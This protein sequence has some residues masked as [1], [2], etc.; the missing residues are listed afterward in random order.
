MPDMKYGDS[1]QARRFSHV[2]GYVGINRIAVRE[3][4]RQ[5][6]DLRLD[7]RGIATG[8]LLV[9]HLVMPEDVSGTSEVLTFVA[10][11]ISPDTC[12]NVMDQYRPCYRAD[13]N[14]T[15]DRPITRAEYARALALAERLGLRRLA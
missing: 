11:E 1:V 6:G 3:M 12:I 10:N 7:E 14:P 4:H 2:R 5:V 8:G 13:E 9:R 15:L